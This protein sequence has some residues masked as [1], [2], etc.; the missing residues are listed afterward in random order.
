MP[1]FQLL[2]LTLLFGTSASFAAA[3][4]AAARSEASSFD[5][6]HSSWT[7]FLKTHVKVSGAKSTVPYAAIKRNPSDLE[8]YVRSL[9]AVNQSEFGSFNV[10]Q[11]LAFLINAYNALT[12]KLVVDHYPVKSIKDIG[13]L[14]SS[15]WKKKFFKLLGKE[16]SLDEIEH[17]MIRKQFAEPRIH[18][19]LVCASTSC[20]ALRPEAFSSTKLNEQLE[21]QARLFITDKDRNR[22]D[23][24]QAKLSLSSIFKWYGTDFEKSSGSVKAFVAP[25]MASEPG[26]KG[27]IQKQEVTILYLDYNWSLNETKE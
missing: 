6:T 10:D 5:Q 9:E 3:P 7:R 12:V 1:I 17:E 24:S 15:P 27:L 26:E 11:K 18:F 4:P 23:P 2:S 14:F 22:F 25:Y 8:A 13:S 21:E 19:A 20:P 16:R